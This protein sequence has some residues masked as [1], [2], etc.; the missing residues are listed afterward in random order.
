MPGRLQG[1]RAIVTGAGSRAPGIGNGRAAAILFAREGADVLLVDR[2][3]DAAAATREMIRADGNDAEIL[4]ADVTSEEDCRAMAAAAVDRW[5]GLDVLHNNVGIGSRGT[6]EQISP[7]EWDDVMRVNVTS[8]MLA[9][10]AAVPAMRRSGGGAIINVSSISALRPR[11]LT[12]YSVS[13]G[14]VATLTQALAVDHGADGIRANCIMPGPVYTPMVYAA[15]MPGELRER[16]RNASL[17][18][19]EGEGWDI[20]WAAVFLASDE[21]RYVT[22]VILPVDGGVTVRGPDR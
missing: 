21:A 19:I 1:K 15:G 14:A 22:G 16:R 8:M 17:L 3:E 13:K 2:D 12:A 11:G 20:G 10:K 18:K 5:G 9:A 4:A 6:V 7:A